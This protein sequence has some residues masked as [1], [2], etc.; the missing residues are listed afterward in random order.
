MTDEL[1]EKV[2]RQTIPAELFIPEF[3]NLRDEIET[4]QA[5][6]GGTV[7]VEFG[8]EDEGIQVCITKPNG[9]VVMF[10]LEE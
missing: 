2:K 3:K 10:I 6:T 9:H 5:M 4:I 7:S 1:Q 8:G